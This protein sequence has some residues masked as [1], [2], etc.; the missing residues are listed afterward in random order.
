[1]AAALLVALAPLATAIPALV[2]LGVVAALTVSLICY[3]T[4]RYAEAREHIRHSRPEA[5]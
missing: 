4:L 5:G 2:A 1:M 3:E